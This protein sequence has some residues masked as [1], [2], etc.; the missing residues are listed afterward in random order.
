[1]PGRICLPFER[2]NFRPH[3]A[4]FC[5]FVASTFQ[6]TNPLL[7]ISSPRLWT[8]ENE[9]RSNSPGVICHPTDLLLLHRILRSLTS[10]SFSFSLNTASSKKKELFFVN[11]CAHDYVTELFVLEFIFGTTHCSNKWRSQQLTLHGI[12]FVSCSVFV[13]EAAAILPT[14]LND[15][16]QS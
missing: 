2:R 1:M 3:K 6:G 5:F 16:F 12:R 7:D 15:C 10:P 9:M 13:R 11:R 8:R 4:F 14:F